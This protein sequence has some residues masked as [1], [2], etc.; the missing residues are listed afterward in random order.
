M[1]VQLNN[2][3]DLSG[4]VPY[5]GA[6]TD[7]NLGLYGITGALITGTSLIKSG[8]TSSQFLKA[9]GSVDGATYLTSY[10]E[11]DPVVKAVNGI[12]K[13]DTTTISV[14]VA[15]VD[16]VAPTATTYTPADGDT[17]TLDARTREHWITLPTSGTVTL[18]VSNA[19]FPYRFI[20]HFTNP[21]SGSCTLAWFT[22]ILWPGGTTPVRTATV[23][24]QDEFSFVCKSSNTYN[25]YSVG[26]NW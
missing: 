7:V 6:T 12:V 22:T 13:S 14:A 8:G 20:V 23:N 17:V 9:D 10:T 26:F 2:P 11:T 18:A 3:P 16:Y 21:A 24:K 5:V 19:A 15:G 1:T 4:L 25:G